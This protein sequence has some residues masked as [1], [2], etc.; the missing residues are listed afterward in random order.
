MDSTQVFAEHFVDGRRNFM[1][2]AGVGASLALVG[3]TDQAF[4]ASS[5]KKDTCCSVSYTSKS[6]KE[7]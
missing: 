6:S 4:A 7:N 5:P 3:G 2:S 1:K